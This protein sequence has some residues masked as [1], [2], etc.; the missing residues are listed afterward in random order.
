MS[1][2]IHETWGTDRGFLGEAVYAIC[3]SDDGYLWIGTERGL[4]RFDGFSFVL[5][6]R[7]IQGLPSSGPVRGLESDAEGGMWIRLDGPHL[8]RYREGR[9]ED[10][11]ARFGLKEHAFTAISKD[12]EG[13]LLLAGL[14]S[15]I[16][17]FRD[18]KLATVANASELSATAN[19]LAA[20]RDGRIWMGS[21]N[22]GLLR[23]DRGSVSSVAKELVNKDI[24]TL[25]AA[26][27]GGLWIGTN[28]GIDYWDGKGLVKLGLPRSINQ[29]QVLAMGKDHDSNVWVGTDHGLVR[30]STSGVASFDPTGRNPGAKTTAVYE[31]HDGALWYGGPQGI[32]RLRDGTFKT[33]ATSEG[34][35]PANNGP[36]YV[37]S[38]GRTWFAPVAG[39]L[40]WL[41]DNHVGHLTIAGL[42]RDVVYSISGGGEEIWIGRQRGGLTRIT[43]SGSSFVAKTYTQADGLPQNS[44]CSVFRNRDG[45]VWAGTLSAGASRLKDGAFTNY[46][47]AN[48][49]PANSVN[50]I[51]EASDGTAWFATPNG[52]ASF[53][54]GHWSNHTVADGLPSADVTIVFEDSR[55]VIWAATSAGLAFV[56]SGH[57]GVPRILPEPL[58]EQIFGITEDKGGSLW[59]ATADRMNRVD[60][61]RLRMGTLD[62]S[63]FQSYGIADGLRGLE[64]V[65]RDRSV[66]AGPLGNVWVSLNRGLAVAS[67]QRSVRNSGPV[68]VRIESTSA[69]GIPVDLRTSPK[70]SAGSKSITFNYAASNLAV[71]ERLKFRYKLD[72]S[73]Q[74]WSSNVTSRQVVYSHLD[75]GLYR[76]RVVA[77]NGEGLWNGPEAS[78]PFVIEPAF[79]QTRWFQM[80]GLV[81]FSLAV[82]GLY[83]LRIYQLT[84]QLNIRFQERLAERT[85]IAQE[86]HDTLLQGVQSAALQLD[87]AEDQLP[88]DSPTKPLLRRILQLMTDVTEEGRNALRGLRAPE[89]D[90]HSLEMAFSRMGKEFSFDAGVGFR[91]IVNSNVRPLRPMIRNEVYR[92]GREAIVNAFM[93]AH[94]QS[95]EVDV[96]YANEHL[97]VLVRD[98]GVGVDPLVLHSGLEGHWG[99]PGMRDRSEAIGASL[100]LRSRLGAGTEVELIVPSEIAFEDAAH[101]RRFHWLPWLR[102]VRLE[103]PVGSQRK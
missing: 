17:R 99:L 50:S 61:D 54:N 36:V 46:S 51:L 27:N 65:R 23:I 37:D 62:D 20:T 1:Q 57:A 4:V 84:Q 94:A 22:F 69:E 41:K 58:R 43:L 56:A 28:A 55:Q 44:I 80:A 103:S 10:A 19:T 63:D 96:E 16:F 6:Q 48:G 97:R 85:R 81:A 15:R 68:A 88:D 93:H 2:Y 14:S 79:W 95:V 101:G 30:I 86:L 102:R 67:P 92:I 78:I 12:S 35:P 5:I 98:N 70:L 83:R 49:M 18:G 42:D 74:D 31:D 38:E 29:S 33:Y 24:N 34:L 8:L 53:A 100:R 26:N 60:R 40:Y 77:S 90:N 3:Q 66:A 87:V 7:P 82:F 59:F 39:G 32:E 71:P 89:T 76:F 21:R 9:F 45:S 73:G 11:Y 91:V 13:G 52:L 25:L 64:G 72:G 47:V 75:P